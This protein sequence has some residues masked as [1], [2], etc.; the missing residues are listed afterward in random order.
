[1]PE[2]AGHSPPDFEGVDDFA[3]RASYLGTAGVPLEVFLRLGDS[4]TTQ[5]VAKLDTGATYCFFGATLADELGIELDWS[6]PKYAETANSRF[7][8]VFQP[9]DLVIPGW[10]VP[11]IGG[12]EPVS[13]EIDAAFAK[14]QGRLSHGG[15]LGMSGFFNRFTVA[16][17]DSRPLLWWARAGLG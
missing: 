6:Q 8:Y 14:F 15:V 16:I 4:T 1:M 10:Q 7:E 17:D 5:F 2:L 9:V 12:K 11:G 3:E 13:V